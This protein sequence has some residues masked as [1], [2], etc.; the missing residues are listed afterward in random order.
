MPATAKE[1]ARE[2]ID[3]LADEATW[4]ELAYAIEFRAAVERGRRDAR[5]GRVSSNAEVLAAMTRP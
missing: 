2:V 3:R 1:E 5:A 4:D